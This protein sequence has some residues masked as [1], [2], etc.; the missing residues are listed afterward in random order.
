MNKEAACT[1]NRAHGA[2]SGTQT[3]VRLQQ[4]LLWPSL[5]KTQDF[6]FLLADKASTVKKPELLVL[7]KSCAVPQAR[8]L[9]QDSPFK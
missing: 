4:S 1:S 6:S 3:G 7:F 2:V 9:T 5:E 8:I